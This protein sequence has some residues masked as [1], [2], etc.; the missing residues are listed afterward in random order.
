[1]NL[2]KD[3]SGNLSGV[4]YE[5]DSICHNMTLTWGRRKVL[6][7]LL[8]LLQFLFFCDFYCLLLFRELIKKIIATGSLLHAYLQ[9]PEFLIAFGKHYMAIA[10]MS[11]IFISPMGQVSICKQTYCQENLNQSFI[12]LQEELNC[13]M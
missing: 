10:A 9:S 13:I 3:S 8:R 4:V 1:M 11:I 6:V 5:R 12:W 2:S 7:M